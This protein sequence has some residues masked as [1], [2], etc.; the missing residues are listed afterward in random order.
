M[1]SA[2]IDTQVQFYD[3]DPMEIMWHGNYVK[4]FE[5]ARCALLDKLEYNYPQ[6]LADG[7]GWPVVD[8][9]VKYVAPARF[10]MRIRVTATLREYL[11]RMVIDYQVTEIATGV[12]LTKGQTT[13]VCVEVDTGAMQFETPATFRGKVEKLR[14]MAA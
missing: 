5:E 9:R 7:Y 12:R 13:M 10:G 3:L 14:D 1:I 8:L 4:L 6:M 2:S 11:N